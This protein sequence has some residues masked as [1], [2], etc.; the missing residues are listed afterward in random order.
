MPSCVPGTPHAQVAERLR[1][2]QQG[3]PQGERIRSRKLGREAK[4]PAAAGA[5]GEAIAG[6][7][8]AAVVAATGGGGAGAAAAAA[9]GGLRGT[10]E[11]EV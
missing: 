2:S 1:T 9:A 8:A 3:Q 6:R 5:G 7:D 11:G 10:G 4:A